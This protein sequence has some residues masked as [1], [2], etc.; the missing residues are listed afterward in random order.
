MTTATT[1]LH[2]S[3]ACGKFH[4]SL[5]QSISQHNRLTCYCKD[6]QAF[7]H[8]LAQDNTLNEQGGTDIVQVP[9]DMV[10]I[11][12]GPEHLAC[13]RLTPG[14]LH[15]WYA[16]CCNT[17]IGNAPG[18]S[19]PFIGLIHSCLQPADAIA[20]AFGP[21]K[22]VVFTNSATGSPKPKS[23]GM[24]TGIIAFIWL[25]LATRW[26]GGSAKHPFFD[27]ETG[28]PVVAPTV[29]NQ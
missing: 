29:L 14:G 11:A 13:L 20:P 10:S 12:K 9:A 1:L 3:C 5:N 7:A 16:S 8:F 23:R 17:P 6:C 26:R 15:R 28:E 19:M 18:K 25:A 27:A 2:I 24:V 4:A 22:M 21:V